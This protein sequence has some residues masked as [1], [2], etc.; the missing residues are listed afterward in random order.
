MQNLSILIAAKEKYLA[1]W[2]EYG[3]AKIYLKYEQNQSLYA[4]MSV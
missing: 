3:K 2:Y 1:L 4:L